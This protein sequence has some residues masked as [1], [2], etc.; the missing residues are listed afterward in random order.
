MMSDDGLPQGDA[1]IVARHLVMSQDVKATSLQPR[2]DEG[3][4]QAILKAAPA[5]G[6]ALQAG[7]RAQK[8]TGGENH[9]RHS[10]VKAPGDLPYRHSGGEVIQKRSEKRPQVQLDCL[11]DE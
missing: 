4:E 7:L 11:L 6:H 3:E 9:L 10:E 5:Q 1:A 8:L 2:H